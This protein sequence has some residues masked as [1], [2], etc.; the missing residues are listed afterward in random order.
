[1]RG[2]QGM[3]V[4]LGT[5]GRA[6]APCSHGAMDPRPRKLC[7]HLPCGPDTHQ[8]RAGYRRPKSLQFLS[9]ISSWGWSL[10]EGPA[11]R[12]QSQEGRRGQR[13][14]PAA[15]PASPLSTAAAS[16]PPPAL[17]L[18]TPLSH[19]IAR[20]PDPPDFQIFLCIL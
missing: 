10:R 12:Q 15:E 2:S 16:R 6:E 14:L 5:V 11:T 7:L 1:M 18:L 9:P 13:G 8:A 19:T 3:T 20:S 17:S 4:P